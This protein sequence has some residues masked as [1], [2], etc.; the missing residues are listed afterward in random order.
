MKRTLTNLQEMVAIAGKIAKEMFHSSG[1][2]PMAWLCETATG[3]RFIADTDAMTNDKPAL[4]AFMRKLFRDKDVVRY[5]QIAEIWE[6]SGENGGR[7]FEEKREAVM[8]SGECRDSEEPVLRFYYILRPT[9]G[10]PTLAPPV[11]WDGSNMGGRFV[12]M[13]ERKPDPLA[14]PA[15]TLH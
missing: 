4:D 1:S 5:V 13:F 10:H 15:A 11:N 7:T 3:E 12:R 9:T 6:R 2:V 14:L 8:L